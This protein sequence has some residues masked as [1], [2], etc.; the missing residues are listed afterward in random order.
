VIGPIAMAVLKLRG[1]TPQHYEDITFRNISLDA[2]GGAILQVQPW[3]QY[4]DL[5]G[6]APPKSVIR[7][8]RLIGL[9]GRYGA[10]GTIRPNPGQTTI[11]GVL[12]K[13]FDV[14]LQDPAPAISGVENL[15][16]ER[17]VVNGKPV[18]L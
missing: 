8:L 12:F 13:D 17:V 9:K 1:D 7:N 10:F 3:T 6:E 5:K 18:S 2:A 15:R 11:D 14:Q 4:F 16:C